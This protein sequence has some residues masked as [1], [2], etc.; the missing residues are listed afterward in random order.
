MSDQAATAKRP[1]IRRATRADLDAFYGPG[2]LPLTVRAMVGLVNGE[3]V[4]CGGISE[5]EGALVAFSDFRPTA[6]RYKLA[7]VKAAAQVIEQA[8]ADGARCIF[9]EADPNEP[10]SVRWM[11]SLGFLPTG[12]PQL[13]RWAAPR[14]TKTAPVA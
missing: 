12:R 3:I 5:T 11:T 6:R 14:P 1:I 9:A 8:K 10:G 7:I 4:G 13:Y 2:R